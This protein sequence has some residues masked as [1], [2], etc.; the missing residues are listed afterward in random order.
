M[1]QCIL[2]SGNIKCIIITNKQ[3]KLYKLQIIIEKIKDLI[4]KWQT[5]QCTWFEKV[6][7]EKMLNFLKWINFHIIRASFFGENRHAEYKMY[8]KVS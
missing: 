4:N 1:I 2:A 5:I 8:M 6:N 3:Q 7:V